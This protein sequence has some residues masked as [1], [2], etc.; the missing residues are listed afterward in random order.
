MSDADS[1]LSEIYLEYDVDTNETN[2]QP[3]INS[4]SVKTIN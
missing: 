4:K 3:L 1:N 2:G